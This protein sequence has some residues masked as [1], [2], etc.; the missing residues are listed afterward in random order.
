M[1]AVWGMENAKIVHRYL[2]AWNSRD[3]A[4]LASQF[5]E[6]G[7]Y[8][9]PYCR[10]SLTGGL[11]VAEHAKAVFRAFEPLRFEPITVI[12]SKDE[13]SATLHYRVHG[14]NVGPLGEFP[15][16]GRS[17]DLTG[18][19]LLSFNSTRLVSVFNHYDRSAVGQQLGH[20][21]Y[22]RL[23]GLGTRDSVPYVLI[24]PFHVPRE[25]QDN[26]VSRWEALTRVLRKQPGFMDA[27]LHRSIDPDAWFPF[28]SATFWASPEDFEKAMAKDEVSQLVGELKLAG[29][30][31]I[32][33]IEVKY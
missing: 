25:D 11:A 29:Y 2:E 8:M 30:P 3:A 21:E 33:R 15:A 4:A 31:A 23:R 9:D 17:V 28:V 32:Y 24:N 10:G 20:P 18:L 22:R 6:H 13:K 12:P 7:T 27:R 16:T 26:L 19:V 1:A 5:G 14:T